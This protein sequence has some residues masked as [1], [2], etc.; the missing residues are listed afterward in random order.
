MA[1]AMPPGTYEIRSAF[2]YWG[3][4]VTVV[5]NG[6]LQVPMTGWGVQAPNGAPTPAN[7]QPLFGDFIVQKV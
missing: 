7:P 3:K 4:A 5:S 6:T 1:V 2:D